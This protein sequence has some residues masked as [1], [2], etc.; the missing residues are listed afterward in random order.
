MCQNTWSYWVSQHLIILG[1]VAQTKNLCDLLEQSIHMWPYTCVFVCLCVCAKLCHWW[2]RISNKNS[3]TM[4]GTTLFVFL[5]RRRPPQNMFFSLPMIAIKNLLV[6]LDWW[7][8]THCRYWTW[9]I[10]IWYEPERFL[11]WQTSQSVCI[12]HSHCLMR[13]VISYI[14]QQWSLWIIVMASL[15]RYLKRHNN[16]TYLGE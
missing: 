15:E 14:T 4:H 13:K 2:Y 1:V 12:G 16:H 3:C 9:R 8:T 11:L 6:S 7:Y 10:W 5:V